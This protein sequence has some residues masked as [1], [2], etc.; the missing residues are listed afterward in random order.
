MDLKNMNVAALS[1][2]QVD[3]VKKYE[4]DFKAKYGS[5]VILIAFRK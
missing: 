5:D 1:D 4:Q 3:A 2:D